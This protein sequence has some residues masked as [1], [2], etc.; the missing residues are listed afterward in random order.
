M[1]NELIIAKAS[2]VEEIVLKALEK[3]GVP[4]ERPGTIKLYS[5]NQI[6]RM[7]GKAH[8]TITK[9]V[10]SG[11]IKSTKDGLITEQ[12]INEYLQIP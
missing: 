6:A 8:R 7:L 1:E 5:V 10:K 3:Y 4:K 11:I 9:L 2:D 12:A